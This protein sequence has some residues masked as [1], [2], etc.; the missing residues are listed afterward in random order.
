MKAINTEF[1]KHLG[2]EF[3]QEIN[4]SPAEAQNW[5]RLERDDDVPEMDYIALREHY[6]YEDLGQSEIQ[7]V[8]QAYKGAFN[9]TFAA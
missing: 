9:A 1:A 4:A 6:H 2:R 7:E 3:A 5:S 8:E